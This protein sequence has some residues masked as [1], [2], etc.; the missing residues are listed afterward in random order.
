M[1]KPEEKAQKQNPGCLKTMLNVLY[2]MLI[3][4]KENRKKWEKQVKA[5]VDPQCAIVKSPA[6]KCCNKCQA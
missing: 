3:I 5:L 2:G 1:P 6:A 4:Q